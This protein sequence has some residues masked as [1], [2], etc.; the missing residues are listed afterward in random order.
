MIV[1]GTRIG[2]D[3][4]IYNVGEEDRSVLVCANVSASAG[5]IRNVPIT[6]STVNGGN[7]G[8]FPHIVHSC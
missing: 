8:K 4:P 7:S 5:S 3:L 6:M 2:F 1:I